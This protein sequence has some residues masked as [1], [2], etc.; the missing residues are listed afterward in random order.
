MAVLIDSNI[1]IGFLKEDKLIVEKIQ[2]FIKNK[3]PI[4]TS[5]ISIYEI[6][7][8]IVANLYLK[9]GRP[10]K[11]PELL[12]TYDKFLLKCGILNFTRESAEKAGDIYAQSQGKGITINEKDCQI[13]GIAL[14][15]GIIE[16]FT[17]DEQDFARIFDIIGLKYMV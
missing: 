10:S 6:Y 14:A 11:V 9:D 13:A 8:G 5:T 3:V 12:A 15:H 16:V 2:D 17:K 1:I 7:T 4:F